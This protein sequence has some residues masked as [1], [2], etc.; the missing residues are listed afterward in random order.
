MVAMSELDLGDEIG[1]DLERDLDA[2]METVPRV[3]PL[4]L[5]TTPRAEVARRAR[6]IALVGGRHFAPLAL[7]S[8][9][10]R[11]IAPDAWARPLRRTFED[12]G[13]TFMKFGQLIGSAPGV[14]GD[15]VADEFRSCLDTGTSVPFDEVRRI[16][17]RDL[18]MPCHAGVWHAW[19]AQRCRHSRGARKREKHARAAAVMRR[20]RLRYCCVVSTELVA[21]LCELA[22][23]LP[24]PI[25]VCG[26][27][28]WPRVTQRTRCCS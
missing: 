27:S 25:G 19:R 23:R 21:F 17:E 20:P 15:A 10:T 8:A 6:Q 4:E 12:L 28:A 14:F 2:R 11:R 9:V 18:G 13:A 1:A 24:A 3:F 5:P 16:V 7:R 26:P 22:R